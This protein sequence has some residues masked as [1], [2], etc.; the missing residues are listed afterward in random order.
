MVLGGGTQAF[1]FNPGCS[2]L[3]WNPTLPDGGVGDPHVMDIQ[4]RSNGHWLVNGSQNGGSEAGPHQPKH[5]K[6]DQRSS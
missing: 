5:R 1:C 6:S 2:T 3:T 4:V